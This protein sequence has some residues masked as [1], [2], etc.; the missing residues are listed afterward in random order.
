MLVR[1]VAPQE[2][3][4]PPST[5]TQ[6]AKP[7]VHGSLVIAQPVAQ[8]FVFLCDAPEFERVIQ[9]IYFGD[10]DPLFLNV[11]Q[12]VFSPKKVVHT[13]AA[14]YL[15]ISH[16]RGVRHGRKYN[17]DLPKKVRI[18]PHWLRISWCTIPP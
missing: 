11:L 17:S 7:F 4:T 16:E 13:N 12:A 10:L 14:H 6:Q 8:S 18:S 3:I 15:I 1:I 2:R 5:K 9:L